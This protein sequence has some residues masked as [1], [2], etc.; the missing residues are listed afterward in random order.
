LDGYLRLKNKRLSEL[1]AGEIQILNQFEKKYSKI[2]DSLDWI[3]GQILYLFNLFK[4]RQAEY[5]ADITGLYFAG[6]AN[7]NVLG[8]LYLFEFFKRQ[9]SDIRDFIYKNFEFLFIHPYDENRKLAAFAAIN[10]IDQKN[11]QNHIL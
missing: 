1:S 7:F 10:E 4:S 6:K 11:L 5:E 3:E 9:R 8:A 2:K